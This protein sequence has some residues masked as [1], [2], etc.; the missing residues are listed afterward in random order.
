MTS[1]LVSLLLL[2]GLVVGCPGGWRR[3]EK[4]PRSMLWVGTGAEMDFAD[5]ASLEAVGVGELFVEAARLSWPGGRPH[6]EQ[7]FSLELPRRTGVTL[8]VAGSWPTGDVQ[9]AP[10]ADALAGE[11]AGLAAAAQGRGLE[12][13]GFHLDVDAGGRLASYAEALSELQSEL[14]GPL[15]LSATVARP[16]L[17][18]PDLPRLAKAVDF[19][20]AFGYGQRPGEREDKRAW[21][22]AQVEASLR[23]LEE[24]DRDYLLAVVTVGRALHLGG[25]GEILAETTRL[26]LADLARRPEQLELTHGFTLEGIDRLVYTFQ[27]KEH[28]AVG[29]WNVHRGEAVRV[30]GLSGYHVEEAQRYIGAL[31]LG[32]RLGYAYYRLGGPDEPLALSIDRL[33]AA[34]ATD[35]ATAAEPQARLVEQAGAAGRLRFLVSLANASDEPTDVIPLGGNYVELRADGG[36]FGAV[37]PGQFLRWELLRPDARGELQRTYREASILRL[38]VPFLDGHESVASGPIEVI[39]GGG[40]P[41]IA[42]GGGFVVPG[43]KTVPVVEAPA[44]PEPAAAAP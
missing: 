24:L 4:A 39:A 28:V 25:R 2:A 37:E 9:A 6:L 27:A 3:L 11:L 42:I 35:T 33:V 18:D 38:Y 10:I 12:A 21:D 29:G 1:R 41:T 23:R 43:G 7:L 14:P 34:L 8:V 40:T 13:L 20:V 26:A 22:L 30:S 31:D 16:W 32:H 44:P 15:L 5:L 17:D 19:F 36:T